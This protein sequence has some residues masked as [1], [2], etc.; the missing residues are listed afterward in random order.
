MSHSDKKIS[1]PNTYQIAGLTTFI[2][3]TILIAFIIYNQFFYVD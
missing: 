1:I 2:Y 3:A